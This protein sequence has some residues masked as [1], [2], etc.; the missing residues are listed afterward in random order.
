M[1][2][3]FKISIFKWLKYTL[4]NAYKKRK[5]CVINEKNILLVKN[6]LT[7]NKYLS[8]RQIA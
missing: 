6:L 8:I 5:N 3:K 2:K 1:N 7:K 4:K